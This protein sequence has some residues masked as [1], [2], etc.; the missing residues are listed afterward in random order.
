MDFNPNKPHLKLEHGLYYDSIK[1]YQNVFGK[2][3][4]KII[5]FEEFIRN[6]KN[7]LEEIL[8]FLNISYP[9][10]DFQNIIHNP[11]RGVRGGK[12]VNYFRSNKI[13]RKIIPK[14]ILPPIRIYLREKIILKEQSKPKLDSND[15]EVL[16]NY[17]KDDVKKVE[18]LLGRKLPWNNFKKNN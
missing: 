14:I 7:S 10:N 13:S 2:K 8:K 17:Y 4:I 6:I 18:N 15:K 5:I 12:I 1:R 11:Y 9:L 3:Q 16:F